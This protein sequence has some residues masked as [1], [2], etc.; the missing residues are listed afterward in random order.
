VAAE[1]T[2]ARVVVTA[3]V[4]TEISIR[5]PQ[6]RRLAAGARRRQKT[7]VA[8]A[9]AQRGAELAAS[10]LSVAPPIGAG[11]TA[12]LALLLGVTRERAGQ[13]A[14]DMAA[15]ISM[16]DAMVTRRMRPTREFGVFSDNPAR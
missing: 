2:C 7:A 4:L 11:F 8:A 14:A 9:G 15:G 1:V 6:Y 12:A 5:D 16:R 13:I 10:A 3:V